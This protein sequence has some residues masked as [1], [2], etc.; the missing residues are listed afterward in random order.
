ME[1]IRD[2]WYVLRNGIKVRC[3]CTDYVGD[4]PLLLQ[5]EDG[6]SYLVRADGTS[7]YTNNDVVSEYTPP[8]PLRECWDV[9]ATR[10]SGLEERLSTSPNEA[11]G[12]RQLTF[13]RRP[14]IASKGSTYRLVHMREVRDEK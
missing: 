7:P 2:K 8:P 1:I 14:G 12:T 5:A 13:Y 9:V 11:D 6:T 10:L 3:I 4:R